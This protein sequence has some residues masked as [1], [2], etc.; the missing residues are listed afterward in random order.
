MATETTTK[1]YTMINKK[2][3]TTIKQA[4]TTREAAR[5]FKASRG[6]NYYIFDNVNNT[7]VR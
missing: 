3:N 1:R 5:S 2:T 4:F 7:V 6:Y